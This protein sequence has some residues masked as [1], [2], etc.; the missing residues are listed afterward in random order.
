[1]R[2]KGIPLMGAGL[3]FPISEDQLYIEPFELP[4]HW[5][6][7]TGIDFGWDHPTAAAC[8]AWDRDSDTVYMTAEYRETRQI[9]AVH[10]QAIKAWGDWIPV[11]W[12]HDGM[13]TE[14]GSG[15]N[16]ADSYRK[17]GLNMLM[18]K[19]SNPPTPGQKE[20]E[21]G[22]SVESSIMDMV[23]RMETGRFKVFKIC[24]LWAQEVRMYHRDQR[25]KIV[26]QADDLISASRYGCMMLRH[27]RTPSVLPRKTSSG[28]RGLTNWGTARV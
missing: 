3:I 17:C 13:N 1:M 23:E 18:H 14:K 28:R 5:P 8:L 20:G 2:S 12:P 11:A 25:G 4:R 19:A 26:K 7:I 6:R 16:L 21:G 24:T 9:P 15:E 10:T 27:A 22:N